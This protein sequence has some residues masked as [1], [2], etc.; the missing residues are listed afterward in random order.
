MNRRNRHIGCKF[1]QG[2]RHQLRIYRL[3]PPH[4]RR[5]LDSY[6]RDAR[7]TITAVGSDRF[8]IRRHSRP[9][10]RVKTGNAQNNRWLLSH[11]DTT[12]DIRI[13]PS[14]AFSKP[15]YFFSS[16]CNL[17]PKMLTIN[18]LEVVWS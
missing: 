4:S 12:R 16:P 5:G 15:K 11:G 13:N 8:N 2:I 1:L 17:V 18:N 9:R 7:H 3:D 6:G 14:A 10:R